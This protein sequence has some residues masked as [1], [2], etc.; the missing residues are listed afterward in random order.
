LWTELKDPS[1]ADPVWENRN[2]FPKWFSVARVI[3]SLGEAKDWERIGESSFDLK[4]TS[5]VE[6][7][8]R[9][10]SYSVRK[11]VETSRAADR[12]G[13]VAEG[14]GRAFLVSSETAYPGWRLEVEGHERPLE[15]VNLGFR[16]FVLDDGEQRAVLTYQPR[17]FRLGCFMSI[18]AAGPLFLG[19]LSILRR[20]SNGGA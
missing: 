12:V 14:R 20:K 13:I 16:G 9:A 3:P 17:S 7:G 15:Q 11:V 18:L 5:L 19:A 4:K 6:D 2:S 8:A 10:G 1:L